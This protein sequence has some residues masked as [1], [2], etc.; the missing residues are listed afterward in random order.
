MIDLMA[1]TMAH[2]DSVL[3]YRAEFLERGDRM[4]G[5]AGLDKVASY[6][7]WLRAVLNNRS[8][9][10]VT[11]GLVPAYTLLAVRRED[12]RLVGMIDIRHRL[13]E[14][15]RRVGGH[16]GYSVRPSERGKGYAKEMLRLGLYTCRGLGLRRVL[17]TCDEGNAASEKVIR[18]Q[19]GVLEDRVEADGHVIFRYIIDLTEG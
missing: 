19:G 11:P 10:T 9:E 6:E 1:P 5:C 7:A 12:G 2:Q 8:A 18:S 13:N 3:A 15:L 16:I 14:Y 4:D 17:I